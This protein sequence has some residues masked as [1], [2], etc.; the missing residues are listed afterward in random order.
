MDAPEKDGKRPFC[1][2]EG[3]VSLNQVFYAETHDQASC[4]EP[5]V[6]KL[7]AHALVGP[8]MPL[9]GS[10]QQAAEGGCSLHSQTIHK[11]LVTGSTTMRDRAALMRMVRL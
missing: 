10:C 2:H 3:A 4:R 9:T 6:A 8:T 7:G 11:E 5:D 1:W